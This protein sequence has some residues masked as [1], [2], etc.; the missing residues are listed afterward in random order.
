MKKLILLL[1]A[2]ALPMLGGGCVGT[3]KASLTMD[4]T[5]DL[6]EYPNPLEGPMKVGLKIEFFRSH[7]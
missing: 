5:I 4:K 2:A 1:V 6:G 3:T 7:R